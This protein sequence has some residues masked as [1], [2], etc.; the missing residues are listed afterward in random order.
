MG[1]AF[2]PI[3]IGTFVAGLVERVPGAALRARAATRRP[4]ACG[5][6]SGAIGVVSTVLML[7]YDR[8]VASTRPSPEGDP[9]DHRDLASDL[10]KAARAAGADAADM[11][12]SRRHGVLGHRPQGR[13]R[14]AERGRQQGARAARLRRAAHGLAYTSDFSWPTLLRLVEDAVAMARATGEDPAAG[15]PDETFPAEDV[16]LEMYDP[17]PLALPPAERIERARRAE[18]AALE[19]PGDHEL[20]GRVV[21]L[22]RGL[23]AARQHASASWAGT[24]PR[25]CRSPS[26]RM[27]ERDGQMERDHWYTTGRGLQD[28]GAPEEVGRIA[29]ERTVRRL[30]ARQVATARCRWCSIPRPR[31][32]ILGSA[33]RRDLGLRRVPQRDLPEGPPRAAGRLAARHARGRRPPRARPRLA[34]LRRRGSADAAQR[35]ARSGRAALLPVRR[36]LRAQDRGEADGHGAP[37]RRRRPGGGRVEPLLRARARRRPRRSS[38]RPGAGSTSPT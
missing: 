25:R 32:E 4:R 8:F 29:A 13:G 3:A 12:V 21:G 6:G 5:C 2:L 35:A 1:F 26:C 37:R 38:P 20:A 28:L 14:D 17:S 10:L 19:V 27:A 33:V 30:G 15:L 24:G 18:A 11:I 31:R 36:V 7:L 9:L 23:A 22:G 16:E 34:A